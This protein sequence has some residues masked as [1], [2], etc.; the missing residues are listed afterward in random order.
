MPVPEVPPRRRA[1][2]TVALIAVA[3]VLGVVGGTAVGYGIQAEREPT[4]LPAL[5]QTDLAYPAKPAPKGQEPPALSVAEDRGLK[6][7]GDLSKLL[8]PKPAGA[9]KSEFVPEDGWRS[10][11]SYASD[12]NG[13]STELAYLLDGGIRRVVTTGWRTGRYKYTEI[14]L[15]QFRS[16][17]GQGA[18]EHSEGQRRFMDAEAGESQPVKGSAD[19]RTYL[20][21]V[22]RKAGYEDMYRARAYVHRGD[23]AVEIFVTDIKKIS[24]K[25]ISSLAERQLGRL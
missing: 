10:V 20:L 23:I 24:Q 12:F 21:P 19:G 14:N 15:V 5:N 9:K 4:P 3:A 22:K 17:G 7:E 18:A 2:R 6:T 1:G 25:E 11:A 8:L 16:D 13:P